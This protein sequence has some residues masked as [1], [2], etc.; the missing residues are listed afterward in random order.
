MMPYARSARNRVP[1]VSHS[2][3]SGTYEHY[4][5][6]G[7]ATCTLG[8]NSNGTCSV[9]SGVSPSSAGNW[10]TGATNGSGYDISFD[11]GGSWL[12]LGTARNISATKSVGTGTTTNGPI[13]VRIRNASTL[14]Q[15]AAG[16]VTLLATRDAA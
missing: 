7:T 10:M 5:T 15:V 8:F 1:P 2:V 11:G 6:S 13:D 3:P 4:V 14:V 9:S 16:S 12:N